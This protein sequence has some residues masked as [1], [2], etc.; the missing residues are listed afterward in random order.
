M[1]DLQKLKKEFIE[2][3]SS[4]YDK[5]GTWNLWD[6]IEENFTPKSS[7]SRPSEAETDCIPK[8]ELLAW[9]VEQKIDKAI[10]YNP[11]IPPDVYDNMLRDMKYTTKG[12]Q[13]YAELLKAF[14]QNHDQQT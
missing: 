4:I 8:S 10:P 11:D 5:Q 9:M 1:T 12:Y 2:R 14:I 7:P 3:A 6:F 13:A